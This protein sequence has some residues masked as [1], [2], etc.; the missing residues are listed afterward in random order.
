MDLSYM[1][2]QQQQQQQQGAEPRGFQPD[3]H[4]QE[5]GCWRRG[6]EEWWPPAE[7]DEGINA[8]ANVVCHR[9]GGSGHYSRECPSPNTK[10]GDKAGKGGGKRGQ[11][12]KE[13]RETFGKGG[14]EM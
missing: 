11:G 5:D 9:C 8:L 2:Q 7:E 14:F 4:Q 10:G 1:Q 6:D 12:A 13:R 3:W